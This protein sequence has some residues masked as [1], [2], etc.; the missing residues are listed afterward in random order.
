M[1]DRV[2]RTRILFF[3]IAI[4]TTLTFLWRFFVPATEQDDPDYF[5]MIQFVGELI[6]PLG[7]IAFFITLRRT[8]P[9][10]EWL[11]GTTF[12]IALIASVGIIG[13][14][15]SSDDGW[16]SGHRQYWPGG[17]PSWNASPPGG[18]FA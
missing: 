4:Y 7:L 18:S 1:A 6:I 14:R 15:L 5:I 8:A 13:M 3:A 11:L 12:A 10:G 16:Y 9:D 2:G 17:H